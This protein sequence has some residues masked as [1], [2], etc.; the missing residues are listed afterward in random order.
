MGAPLASRV[1]IDDATDSGDHVRCRCRLACLARGG[2]QCDH[3]YAPG[4]LTGELPLVFILS[5]TLPLP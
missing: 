3:C 4:N 2:H 1:L 5:V